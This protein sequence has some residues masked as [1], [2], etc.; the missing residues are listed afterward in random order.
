MD[1]QYKPTDPHRIFI[2]LLWRELGRA[3]IVFN[4]N[5]AH[6]PKWMLFVMKPLTAN[7]IYA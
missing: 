2:F 6:W 1:H 5:G 4:D 3:S 7:S